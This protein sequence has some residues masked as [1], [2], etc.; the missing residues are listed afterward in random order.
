[1]LRRM[2]GK[3]VQFDEETWEA[4]SAVARD[5]GVT[6]QEMADEAF[7]DYLKK[8]KQPVGLIASLKVRRRSEQKAPLA[9]GLSRGGLNDATN[10]AVRE[11]PPTYPLVP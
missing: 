10:S 3:R 11:P 6:F 2:V 7:A 9:A 4:L 5:K 1:M 8:H